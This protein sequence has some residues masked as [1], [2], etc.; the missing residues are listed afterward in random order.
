MIVLRFMLLSLRC[1]SG[2]Q[3]VP[4]RLMLSGKPMSIML[5]A[6]FALCVLSTLIILIGTAIGQWL[7]RREWDT[8]AYTTLEIGRWANTQTYIVDTRVGL[9][10]PFPHRYNRWSPDGEAFAFASW[11]GESI[12]IQVGDALGRNPQTLTDAGSRLS[13][14]SWSPDGQR[15]MYIAE[16]VLTGTTINTIGIDGTNEERWLYSQRQVLAPSWSPDGGSALYRSVRDDQPGL[17]LV[18]L[19][20]SDHDIRRITT[21]GYIADMPAWSPDGRFIAFTRGFRYMAEGILVAD[22][23]GRVRKQLSDFGSSPTW[24]NDGERIVF[25][26]NADWTFYSVDVESGE[27]APFYSVPGKRDGYLLSMPAWRGVM[28]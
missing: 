26:D 22:R 28:R 17:F 25:L 6:S 4:P 10:L 11:T 9:T 12:E 8:L 15:L 27:L 23:W 24:S 2:L 5:T 13:M 18:A 1:V 7:P 19:D 14:L 3:T 21:D 20:P 16:G